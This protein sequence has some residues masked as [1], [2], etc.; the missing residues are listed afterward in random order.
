VVE[1]PGFGNRP[2]VLLYLAV[3][4]VLGLAL[5]RR[6]SFLSMQLASQTLIGGLCA[7]L[8]RRPFVALCTTSGEISEVDEALRSPLR[9]LHRQNLRRADFLVGQSSEAANE[10]KAFAPAARIAVV[11]NPLPSVNGAALGGRPNAVFTGRLSRHKDLGV[12]LEAWRTVA[13]R[14]PSARLW[15]VGSGGAYGSVES[16]LRKAVKAHESLRASV[17]F[18]GWVEDVKPWLAGADVYVFPSRSEGLS[19]ALLEACAWR[20]IV[21]ASDIASNREV[22]GEDYPLLFETG[23]AS[24]LAAALIRAFEDDQVRNAAVAAIVRRVD[25]LSRTPASAAVGELLLAA[26]RSRY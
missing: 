6:A 4:G 14:I 26:D 24:R 25:E 13:E 9:I 15:L 21:V 19:N 11:H 18:T 20:R 23:N 7:R 22:L 2:G 8:W 5:G 3:G 12:L 17:T 10:L 1:V 16:E